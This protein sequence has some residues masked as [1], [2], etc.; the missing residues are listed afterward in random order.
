M[1]KYQSLREAGTDAANY[2]LETDDIIARL[3]LWDTSYGIELSDVTFDAVVVT[4]KS[5]P[6]DLTALSAEIYEFCPDTIDQ[7]FGCIA[8][9]I[10]MAEEVGQEIPADLR[11]LLEGVDLTD[12]NYGLELLQRSLCNSKT[13]ALWWD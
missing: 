11:Q 8:D 4:F 1:D 10:E 3:K 12:E 6:A 7:H 13:V 5:L 9:M 2:D